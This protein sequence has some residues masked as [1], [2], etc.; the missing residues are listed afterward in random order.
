MFVRK[1]TALL[2]LNSISKFSLLVEQEVVPLL[3]EQNGFQ[4][5]LAVFPISENGA[6]SVSLEHDAM[7]SGAYSR[8]TYPAVRTQLA[9]IIEGTPT[10]DTYEIVNSTF[11]KIA[12]PAA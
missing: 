11:H 4:D 6:T 5:E 12:A 1:A 8:R 7:N 9:A 2:K 10:V 3:R